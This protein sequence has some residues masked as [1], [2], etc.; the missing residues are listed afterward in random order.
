MPLCTTVFSG[1]RSDGGIILT[2]RFDHADESRSKL[3]TGIVAQPKMSGE[4]LG[5]SGWHLCIA[6]SGRR[7]RR[8]QDG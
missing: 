1:G 3:K 7:E 2:L 6:D 5:A 4:M 8:P